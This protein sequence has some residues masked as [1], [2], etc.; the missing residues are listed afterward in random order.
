MVQSRSD[1]G[2]TPRGILKI[3]R[4]WDIDRGAASSWWRFV[5]AI[6]G[7]VPVSDELQAESDAYRK[8]LS[9]YFR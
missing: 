8:T 7:D 3:L 5:E 1:L 9:D 2:G 4:R 6:Y